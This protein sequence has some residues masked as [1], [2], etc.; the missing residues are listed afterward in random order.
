MFQGGGTRQKIQ[1]QV[2]P[3]ALP[4]KNCKKLKNLNFQ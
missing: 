1:W 3:K 2:A 4:V